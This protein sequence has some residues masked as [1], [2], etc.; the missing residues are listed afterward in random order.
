MTEFR[1]TWLYAGVSGELSNPAA[2]AGQDGCM[3][4]VNFTWPDQH[5][6]HWVW[7][8]LPGPHIWKGV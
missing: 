4:A 8:D 6:Q 7:V 1:L 5:L 2:M 3:D